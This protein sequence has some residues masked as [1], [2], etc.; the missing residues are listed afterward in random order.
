MGLVNN[1][2]T[3]MKCV[4]FHPVLWKT[5]VQ[6]MGDV[7]DKLPDCE[8]AFKRKIIIASYS[9]LGRQYSIVIATILT[10]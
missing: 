4:L 10:W 3:L 6:K 9:M 8:C 7:S 5:K 2:G 1:L